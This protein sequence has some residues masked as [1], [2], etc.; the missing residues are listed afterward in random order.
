MLANLAIVK[1]FAMS[2]WPVY[3]WMGT[4]NKPLPTVFTPPFPIPDDD[5]VLAV[6]EPVWH[7]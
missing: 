6:L 4:G 7:V 3:K 5:M 2:G 1:E